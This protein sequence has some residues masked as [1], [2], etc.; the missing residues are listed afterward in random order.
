MAAKIEQRRL[1]ASYGG[2]RAAAA[3]G[4][5]V[6]AIEGE[7]GFGMLETSMRISGTNLS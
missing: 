6:R 1:E 4:D 2:G 3:R 5:Q 7:K